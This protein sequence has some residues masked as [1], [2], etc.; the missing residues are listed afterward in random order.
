MPEARLYCT[1]DEWLHAVISEVQRS[2]GV[3]E[4]HEDELGA[5]STARSL[6][7]HIPDPRTPVEEQ[8]LRGMLVE[9]SVWWAAKAHARAHGGDVA[10]CSFRAENQVHDAWR[11]RDLLPNPSKRVFTEWAAEY[12]RALRRAH[13]A[14]VHEAARW[15]R[16]HS[17]E[18]VTLRLVA[19][20][21][22][23]H[24]VA[25]RR[26]FQ[27]CFGLSPHAYHQRTRLADTMRLLRTGSHDARS[28]LYTA[29]WS[30]P[31]SLYRAATEIS[32]KSVHEL[33]SLPREAVELALQ[34]PTACVH[35]N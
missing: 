24:P 19:R 29:G 28:A 17:R 21:V 35:S 16:E 5:F 6:I 1:A 18:R 7:S 30:S 32:G 14:P 26:D 34:L 13:P 31:K 23:V 20:A 25:L 3:I 2:I 4:F 9:L 27:A 10:S 22:G 15:I 12:F 33:R 11:M 8:L